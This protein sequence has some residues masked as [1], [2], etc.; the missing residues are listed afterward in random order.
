V[1]QYFPRRLG[2][3]LMGKPL[4]YPANSGCEPVIADTQSLVY[5]IVP[6]ITQRS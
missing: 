6:V 5:V 4:G 2:D 3:V 1:L